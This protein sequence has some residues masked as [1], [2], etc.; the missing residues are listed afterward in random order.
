MEELVRQF[1]EFFRSWWGG[2]LDLACVLVVAANIFYD[3]IK[4]QVNLKLAVGELSL[5]ISMIGTLFIA[6]HM[7]FGMLAALAEALA[8]IVLV[9]KARA[10]K[11]R[12]EP[13]LISLSK[14]WWARMILLGIVMAVLVWGIL[15]AAGY[16]LVAFF[17]LGVSLISYVLFLVIVAQRRRKIKS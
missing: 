9:T 8:L 1:E 10:S 6:G 3:S 13:P 12:E 5:G 15:W 4:G 7:A 14:G 17:F 2:L 16:P 11:P